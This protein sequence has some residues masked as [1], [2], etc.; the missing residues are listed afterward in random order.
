MDY[1][2]YRGDWPPPPKWLEPHLHK[3]RYIG[4]LMIEC[5]PVIGW[6]TVLHIIRMAF[7]LYVL[8]SFNTAF[9]MVFVVI[10]LAY[11]TKVDREKFKNES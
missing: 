2:H 8:A 3:L 11:N 1:Q 6:L 5:V 10:C 9:G 4:A 7:F